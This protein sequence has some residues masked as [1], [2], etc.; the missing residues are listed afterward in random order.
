MEQGDRYP[1]AKYHFSEP[2]RR[3]LDEAED[4]ALGPEWVDHPNL[5]KPLQSTVE[6]SPPRRGPG[7]P[8]K[9]PTE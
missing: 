1:K 4:A 5:A 7:R 3:V 9:V 8:P 6:M 2:P